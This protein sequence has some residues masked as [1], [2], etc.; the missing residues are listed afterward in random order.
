MKNHIMYFI[1]FVF[2][3][4]Y[5]F[6]QEF[7]T[8]EIT[9]LSYEMDD[10]HQSLYLNYQSPHVSELNLDISKELH[11]NANLLLTKTNA[12]GGVQNLYLR[13]ASADQIQISYDG[14]VLN[15]PSHISRGY[16]FS[17]LSALIS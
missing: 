7:H 6:S 9:V 1:F 8:P 3:A 13:G 2:C 15:D 14:A 12:I 4:H 17:E 10:P 16:N 5:G 11:V